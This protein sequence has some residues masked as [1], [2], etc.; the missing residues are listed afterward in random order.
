MASLHG[1]GQSISSEDLE[2]Q[3]LLHSP[4]P[5]HYY[6]PSTGLNTEKLHEEGEVEGG[7]YSSSASPP[8][9]CPADS[10]IQHQTE[11]IQK[12]PL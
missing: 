8:L 4:L 2:S 10:V 11:F 9:L 12:E 1:D 5:H 6:L 3:D 7:G